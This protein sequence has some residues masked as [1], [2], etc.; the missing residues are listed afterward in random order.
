VA[1]L[2]KGMVCVAYRG[3][4]EAFV[5]WP[6]QVQQVAPAAGRTQQAADEDPWPGVLRTLCAA[7]AV[8]GDRTGAQRADINRYEADLQRDLSSIFDVFADTSFVSMLRK[9]A[10]LLSWHV[11]DFPLLSTSNG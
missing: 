11:G 4:E 9:L 6:D 3:P 7:Q 8:C 10:A 1:P 2:S 5:P